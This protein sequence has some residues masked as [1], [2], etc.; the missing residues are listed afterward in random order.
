M[1]NFVD[2]LVDEKKDPQLGSDGKLG[3]LGDEC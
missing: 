2:L 1:G 3:H